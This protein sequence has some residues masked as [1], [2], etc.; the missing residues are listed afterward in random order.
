M[1]QLHIF[2]PYFHGNE[3][4]FLPC[5][6]KTVFGKESLRLR[7]GFQADQRCAVGERL[8]EAEPY[9]QITKPLAPHVGKHAHIAHAEGSVLP[10]Q[11]CSPCG[12]ILPE[13]HYLLGGSIQVILSLVKNLLPNHHRHAKIAAHGIPSAL[14]HFKNLLKGM[15]FMDR[16]KIERIN[17]LAKIRKERPL[18]EEEDA[19]RKALYKEYLDAFRA[20]TEAV[21]Q[22]IRIQE[23][24]GSLTPLQK[25]T[26]KLN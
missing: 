9:Q 19:E 14:Y 25:K 12:H 7:R 6:H 3:A 2:T 20:N 21:L 16:E 11:P 18:T 26:D 8:K 1:A 24:D 23:K 5:S 17:E 4:V 10:P 15:I 22:S 13:H